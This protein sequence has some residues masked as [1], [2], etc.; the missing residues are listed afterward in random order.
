[1][2]LLG[3]GCRETLTAALD[4]VIE[5]T[6]DFTDSAYTSHEHRENILLLCDRAQLELN[7]LLRIGN[8]M[9]RIIESIA[10]LLKIKMQS[11]FDSRSTVSRLN[12]FFLF[13]S[14]SSSSFSLDNM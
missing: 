11:A 2:T 9:V 12:V 13:F 1:M 5:R 6:Q 8:S 14:S 3:P 4:T 7:T 10:F